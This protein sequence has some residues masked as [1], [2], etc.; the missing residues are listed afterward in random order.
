MFQG[1]IEEDGARSEAGVLRK[2]DV[3]AGTHDFPSLHPAELRAWLQKICD[4]FHTRTADAA[5]HPIEAAALLAQEFVQLHPFRNG[6]GRLCR[7]LFAAA[8]EWQGLPFRVALSSGR[9][10]SRK[11]YVEALQDAQDVS[12]AEPSRYRQLFYLAVFSVH[13]VLSNF[14]ANLAYLE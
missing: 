12:R 9:S 3:A 1:A 6:N 2:T 7:L 10:K 11:H 5:V 4:A 13:R 8:L 14:G